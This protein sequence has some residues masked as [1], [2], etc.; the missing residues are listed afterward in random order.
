MQCSIWSTVVAT[1]YTIMQCNA[2]QC[3][4]ME[5]HTPTLEKTLCH[6]PFLAYSVLGLSM[7]CSTIYY[8][9]MQCNAM[10]QPN[11]RKNVMSCSVPGIRCL[12]AL[13]IPF[14]LIFCEVRFDWECATAAI[15]PTVLSETQAA[16]LLRLNVLSFWKDC[17]TLAAILARVLVN[18][19]M[20]L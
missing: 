14:S 6:A 8:N 10:A 11:A 17:G 12:R 20:A 13:P 9:T 18:W 7:Q 3:N 15:V 1:Q 19:Y 5:W 2:M 16:T 4:A